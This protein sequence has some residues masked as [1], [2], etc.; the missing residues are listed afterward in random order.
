MQTPI[1]LYDNR[2]TDG[3]L[4]ATDT[5]TGYDVLNL[6]DLRPYTFWKAAS[7]GTKYITVD[8]GAAKSADCLAIIGHNLYTAGATVSIESSPDNSSWTV[9]LAGFTPTSDKAVLKTFTSASAQY[10]R[11]KIVTAA[12]AA[13]MAV[14]LLGVKIQFEYPPNT[15]YV[16]YAETPAA[17]VE[18]SKNGHILGVATYSPVLRIQPQFSLVSRTWLDTYFIPFWQNYARL[19]KPFF[20]VWDLDTYPSDVF[21][22]SIDDDMPLETP[23]SVLTYVDTLTLKLRGVKEV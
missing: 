10:W 5:E 8:C 17:D 15:P 4:V 9:R 7:H 11:I 19:F 12:V 22:T 20:F 2:L 6:I 1:I 14:A 23:F 16:P 13:Y 21:F 3:T 18:R